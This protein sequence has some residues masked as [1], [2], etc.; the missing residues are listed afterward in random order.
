MHAVVVHVEID[1]SRHAEA[2]QMLHN[3]VVPSVKQ[4]PGLVGTYWLLSEDG[5]PRS[6]G[7]RVRRQGRGAAGHR[8]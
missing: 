7:D 2:E 3:D 5:T 6:L 8:P 1:P 4:A